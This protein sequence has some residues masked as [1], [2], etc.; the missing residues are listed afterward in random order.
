MNFFLRNENIIDLQ[1]V[2]KNYVKDTDV[3]KITTPYSQ[4]WK[5][6]PKIIRNK[7]QADANEVVDTARNKTKRDALDV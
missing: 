2:H 5:I 3:F 1:K 4:S 6:G 7:I